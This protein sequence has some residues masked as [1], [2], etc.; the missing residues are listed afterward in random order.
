AGVEAAEAIARSGVD[1]VFIGTGDLALSLGVAPGSKAHEEAC[2]K[3]LEACKA[4]KIQ[5]GCFAMGPEAAVARIEQGFAFTVATIDIVAFEATT[6]AAI[7]HVRAN[8]KPPAKTRRRTKAAAPSKTRR[9]TT[10]RPR[11]T[12]S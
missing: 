7:E 2:Q 5:A 1:M 11:R 6:R 12:K 8:A 9:A 4:A 3:V 10:R